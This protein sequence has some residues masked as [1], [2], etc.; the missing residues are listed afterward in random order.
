MIGGNK[1]RIN[2]VIGS[3]VD[4]GS[5]CICL[6]CTGSFVQH[7]CGNRFREEIAAPGVVVRAG[8]DDQG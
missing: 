1:D 7:E 4:A 5:H 3:T 2:A 6:R 8:S